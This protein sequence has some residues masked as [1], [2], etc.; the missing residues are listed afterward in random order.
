M[1]ISEFENTQYESCLAVC[2][3][4]I[5]TSFGLVTCTQKERF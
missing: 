2:G 5:I 4:I 1:M 3:F